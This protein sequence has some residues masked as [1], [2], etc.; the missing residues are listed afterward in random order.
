MSGART[1]ARD[2]VLTVVT[3]LVGLVAIGIAVLGVRLLLTG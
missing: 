2:V 1:S 3:A